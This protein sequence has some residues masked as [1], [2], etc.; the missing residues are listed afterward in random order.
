MKNKYYLYA[1]KINPVFIFLWLSGFFI[2]Y[3]VP[4][5]ASY[6]TCNLP[7]VR[8]TKQHRQQHSTTGA[9]IMIFNLA[10]A[11]SLTFGDYIIT[12]SIYIKRNPKRLL[13]ITHDPWIQRLD[14]Y[15]RT[16]YTVTETCSLLQNAADHSIEF[17]L[18]KPTCT[19][20]QWF[21]DL[22]CN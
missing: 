14:C 11:E 5:V 10:Y 20:L 9:F 22:F 21:V 1:D 18:N 13:N 15:H 3:S 17:F 7:Y 8:S 12:V 2:L 19:T 16:T 6:Y 4:L